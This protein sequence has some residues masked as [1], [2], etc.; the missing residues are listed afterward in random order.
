MPNIQQVNEVI[1]RYRRNKGIMKKITRTDHPAIQA[2]EVY[3]KSLQRDK[4]FLSSQDLFKINRFFVFDHR[5]KPGTASYEAWYAINY[6]NFCGLN[7]EQANQLT[8]LLGHP[9]PMEYS[10]FAT[11]SKAGYQQFPEC[12]SK[13]T[14]LEL[15][16]SSN[17]KKMQEFFQVLS[18]AYQEN[19][20]TGD[21]FLALSKLCVEGMLSQENVA[22]IKQSTHANFLAKCLIR[23]K[24]SDTLTEENRQFI[25]SYSGSFV[26][27]VTQ[28]L[29]FLDKTGLNTL[30]N[31]KILSDF[32]FPIPLHRA[33]RFL[34]KKGLL[35]Q[36]SFD[37]ISAENNI[38][39]LLALEEMPEELITTEIW[40]GLV[41]LSKTSHENDFS[42]DIK[43]YAE[44]IKRKLHVVIEK[45]RLASEDQIETQAVI[46]T[47]SAR[48][49]FFSVTSALTQL[50][51]DKVPDLNLYKKKN[52]A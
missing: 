1:N 41:N 26:I 6:Q 31:R 19:S 10:G 22:H 33:L 16:N 18:Q 12:F 11:C 52:S 32:S 28:S 21:S 34:E 36:A 17:A 46:S 7:R 42:K 40:E 50:A 44:V 43:D 9:L 51:E 29:I 14:L 23:M 37:L 8:K 39:W 38:S 3:L 25:L 13:L 45:D 20:L 30:N 4:D 47:S 35:T 2:T 24:H 48:A 5:V 49:R 15:D 27:T